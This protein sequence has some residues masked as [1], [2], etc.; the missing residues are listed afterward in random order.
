MEK[1]YA[2]DTLF[3][4]Q[5]FF[6]TDVRSNATYFSIRS[7]EKV[8]SSKYTIKKFYFNG[9]VAMELFFL[10]KKIQ[11]EKT[12]YENGQLKW[13]IDFD[14]EEYKKIVSYWRKGQLKRN[15]L[16]EKGKL[17]DGKCYD[18]VGKQII[19]TDFEVMP[20][21]PGGDDSLGRFLSNQLQ[22]PKDAKGNYL[23][24]KVIVGFIV[25]K[26]GYI[27]E[28]KIEK[29]ARKE[30]DEEAMR[31][32]KLLPKWIPGKQD[33]NPIDVWFKLP[34]NFELED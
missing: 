7:K 18:P 9:Q 32:V 22:F 23:E 31:V 2:Q 27:V 20:I 4:N 30:L 25:S 16:F 15:D 10:N 5:Y 8:D 29:S 1:L 19:H 17:V 3:Y 34:I 33:G 21:F 6:D 12:Y 24:G 26:E 28:T 13:S 11:Q 14:N